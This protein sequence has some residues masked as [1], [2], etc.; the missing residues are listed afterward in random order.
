MVDLEVEKTLREIRERVR[1]E[2]RESNPS[3]RSIARVP[4][5]AA[6]VAAEP[7]GATTEARANVEAN[8]AIIARAWDKLPP[9]TSYRRGWAA[10]LELWIKQQVKRAT[11]WFTWEQVNFNAAVHHALRDTLAALAALDAH[12]RQLARMQNDYAALLQSKTELE[13]KLTALETRLASEGAEVREQ[14]T[15]SVVQTRR[16]VAELRN[17]IGELRNEITQQRNEQHNELRTNLRAEWR[18]E[19]SAQVEALRNEQRERVE[20]LTEEQRVG[21]RQL[22]LEA[23]ETAVALDRARRNLE[24]RLDELAKRL[25]KSDR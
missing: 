2:A 14:M 3:A 4:D 11:H 16:E 22:S 23:T 9:L 25:E 24:Q 1:A 17:E 21:F 6:P 7:D 10:R 13:S 5:A 12:E 8:L 15:A 20:H 19:Q 18:A